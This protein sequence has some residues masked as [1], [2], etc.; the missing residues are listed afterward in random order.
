MCPLLD[1][2]CGSLL[3]VTSCFF[4]RMSEFP[5]EEGVYLFP[6]PGR[7]IKRMV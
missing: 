6:I 3:R 5:S 4:F 1:K 7:Q 2:L